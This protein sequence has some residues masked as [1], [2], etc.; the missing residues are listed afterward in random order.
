MLIYKHIVHNCFGPRSC[1]DHMQKCYKC[2]Y[3]DM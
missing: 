3:S 2:G 1:G